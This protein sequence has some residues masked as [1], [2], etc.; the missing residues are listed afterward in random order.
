MNGPF[1]IP[2]VSSQ[3]VISRRKWLGLVSTPALAASLGGLAEQSTLAGEGADK[4]L[5]PQNPEGAGFHNIRN[6]GARGDGKTLDTAAV[7]A[8]IDACEKNKG[9]IVLVPAGDFVVGTIELKSNVTLHLAAAG[10][11]LGSEKME[12][13]SAGKSVPP[14]NGNVV[15]L[16][17]ANAENVSIEGKGTIDGQG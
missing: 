16:Y 7:Q 1:Q 5:L 8:A 10:R 2:A 4:S 15:L 11:L 17:A 9:G 3:Q 12:H 13:Y 6:Y 14:G